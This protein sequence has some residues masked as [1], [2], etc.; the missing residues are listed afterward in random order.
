MEIKECI[1][2]NL[3]ELRKYK[4]MTQGELAAMLNYSDKAI[5]KWEHGE[6]L[7]DIEVLMQL[8]EIFGI[9]LNDIVSENATNAL[10]TE[11]KEDDRNIANQI[12]ITC[13]SIVP[14]WFVATFIFITCQVIKGIVFFPIFIWAIPVS[15]IIL[16]V[17][18]GIWG[19]RKYTFIIVSLLVWSLL[20]AIY[21]Q[22]F[23]IDKNFIR[24]WPIFCLGIPLQIAIILWSQLKRK[25]KHMQE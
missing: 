25:K 4:K 8:C 12:I 13:L 20:A 19:K 3:V 21:I 11:K 2:K 9:T 5:S 23:Y 24:L 10:I 1:A 15:S 18:N 7:P 14:A 17:F 6:A 22:L 16:I